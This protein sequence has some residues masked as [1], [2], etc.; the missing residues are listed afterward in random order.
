LDEKSNFFN[1]RSVDSDDLIG[2]IQR[3][4]MDHAPAA[5]SCSGLRMSQTCGTR[6]GCKTLQETGIK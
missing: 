6:N 2:V 4:R 1:V 3:E 5:I